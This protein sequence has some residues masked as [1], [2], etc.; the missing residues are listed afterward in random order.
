ME[1]KDI[2]YYAVAFFIIIVSLFIILKY[3]IMTP[4][5]ILSLTKFILK[6]NEALSE[7]LDNIEKI[8]DINL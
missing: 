1:G 2:F 3:N 5:M 7:I 4:K 6:G 8:D